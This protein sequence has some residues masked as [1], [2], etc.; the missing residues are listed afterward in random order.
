MLKGR[1]I[2]SY[3]HIKCK[4]IVFAFTAVIIERNLTSLYGSTLYIGHIIIIQLL[5]PN[6]CEFERFKE[7][8]YVLL[9]TANRGM[10]YWRDSSFSSDACY[11][12]FLQFCQTPVLLNVIYYI[13]LHSTTCSAM[14]YRMHKTRTV[15]VMQTLVALWLGGS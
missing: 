5:S 9:C 10:G 4:Q 12:K 13:H 3:R 1:C 7:L 11:Y 14:L 2:Q 6:S 8:F 15:L